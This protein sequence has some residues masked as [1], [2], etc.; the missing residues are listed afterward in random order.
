MRPLDPDTLSLDLKPR[1]DAMLARF[2]PDRRL[3][4]W[5]V[6]L[7]CQDGKPRLAGETTLHPSCWDDLGA[8]M[9]VDMAVETLSREPAHVYSPV[10]NL[11][12]EPRHAAELVSQAP[13]GTQLTVVKRP[14]GEWWRVQTPDGYVA[15]GRSD[16][17]RLASPAPE[18]LRILPIVLEAARLD[19]SGPIPLAA[20]SELAPREAQA[21]H[22]LA[23]TP[24]GSLV[25]IPRAAALAPSERAELWR[26]P[27]ELGARA[28]DIAEKWL[29]V[30]Y[31]WGGKSGW[32]LDCSGLTQLVYETLGIRLPRDADQ[33]LKALPP[34]PGWSELAVGDLL[35][36]PG[37]VALWAGDGFAIHASSPRGAVVREDVSRVTWLRERCHAIGRPVL[38]L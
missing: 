13:L 16:N 18:G 36:Y 30:P 10:L 35:F 22:W 11:R 9:A 24:D 37:H 17:I 38:P 21:D 2:L 5:D 3:G 7:T 23:E 29:G 8:D 12:R 32:G 15:W 33:Q 31:L 28:I 20:G 1:I 27:T 14:E 6:Q 19:G 26:Q 34:V 4:V 25:R